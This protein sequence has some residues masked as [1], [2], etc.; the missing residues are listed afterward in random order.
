MFPIINHAWTWVI[1]RLSLP[2]LESN[3]FLRLLF[4]YQHLTFIHLQWSFTGLYLSLS[5]GWTPHGVL[6]G[7]PGLEL[8]DTNFPIFIRGH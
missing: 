8:E 4:I 2:L 6:V 1:S 5:V 7:T 3:E